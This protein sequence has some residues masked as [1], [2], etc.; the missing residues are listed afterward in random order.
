MLGFKRNKRFSEDEPAMG[1]GASMPEDLNKLPRHTMGEEAFNLIIREYT[2]G[3]I[4][5]YKKLREQTAALAV[6]QVLNW[7][8]GK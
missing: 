8:K 7:R 5:P 2:S 3:R 4:S 1:V 6:G